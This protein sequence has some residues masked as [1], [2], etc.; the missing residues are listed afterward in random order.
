[1]EY[2]T[3]MMI[4]MMSTL[5]LMF[6]LSTML[7]LLVLIVESW[8]LD[9]SYRSWPLVTLFVCDNALQYVIQSE[10]LMNDRTNNHQFCCLLIDFCCCSIHIDAQVSLSEAQAGIPENQRTV[11]LVLRMRNTRKELNDIRFEFQVFFPMTY[12][13]SL[14]KSKSDRRYNSYNSFSFRDL[15][16]SADQRFCWRHCQRTPLCRA[17]RFLSLSCYLLTIWTVSGLSIFQYLMGIFH[18]W[19][20]PGSHGGEPGQIDRETAPEQEPHVQNICR[21]LQGG[22]ARWE[23]IARCAENMSFNINWLSLLLSGFA[24]LS[25]A[26]WQH[27]DI[28]EEG[29]EEINRTAHLIHMWSLPDSWGQLGSVPKM[30]NPLMP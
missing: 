4:I 30:V 20:W 1:M 22:N 26:D 11:N 21:Y 14:Q 10:S 15:L 2:L 25:I 19:W 8:K 28:P 9:I 17:N 23:G 3:I 18:S 24:Q 5:L 13:H 29:Q 27:V 7:L 12:C 16:F 6:R